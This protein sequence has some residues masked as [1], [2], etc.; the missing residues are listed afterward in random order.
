MSENDGW[1][2]AAGDAQVGPTS[3][4]DIDALIAAGTITGETLVWKPGMG[5]WTRAAETPLGARL[6]AEV[7]PP[8]LPAW[9]ATGAPAGQADQAPARGGPAPAMGF[10]EAARY[11]LEN[12]VTFSG[13]GSRSEYWYFFLLVILVGAVA[14]LVDALFGYHESGPVSGLA[15]LA[16]LLP[17]L[18]VTSRRF[19]DAGWSFWWWLLVLVPIFGWLFILYILV[20][21]PEPGPNRFDR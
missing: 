3:E 16:L 8:P 11:C 13:R 18:A 14:S 9:T 19:H 12:Y 5:V 21:R 17:N 10:Q 1:Y 4:M 15:S 2:Y 20:L 6:K 7:A